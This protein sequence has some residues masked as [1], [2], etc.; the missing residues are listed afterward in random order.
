MNE[1]KVYKNIKVTMYLKSGRIF[2]FI[3]QTLTE[4]YTI[5]D[6]EQDILTKATYYKTVVE[7]V[8]HTIQV[9]AIEELQCEYI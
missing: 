9:N 5:D 6:L 8:S 1:K 7:G 2:Q 4:G 3:T